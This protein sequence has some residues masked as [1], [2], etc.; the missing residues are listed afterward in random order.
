VGEELGGHEYRDVRAVSSIFTVFLEKFNLFDGEI[1]IMERSHK[2][3]ITEHKERLW[4]S[5][6]SYKGYEICPIPLPIASRQWDTT[7][8]IM[9]RREDGG[10][11]SV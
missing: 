11:G 2:E 7:I 10:T 4:M 6:V 8:Y 5:I 3:V 9:V 1:G